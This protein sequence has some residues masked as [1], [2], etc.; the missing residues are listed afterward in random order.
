MKKTQTKT[1][2]MKIKIKQV[3]ISSYKKKISLLPFLFCLFS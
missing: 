1:A 3:S 2:L